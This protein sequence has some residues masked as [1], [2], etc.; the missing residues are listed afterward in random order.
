MIRSTTGKF[1]RIC[2]LTADQTRK[3]STADI[4]QA[5]QAQANVIEAAIR[6]KPQD[7]FWF[8]KR[9]KS[10]YKEIYNSSAHFKL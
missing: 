4:L 2:R 8:H 10:A 6:A 7:W 5:T 1:I 9:W 3:D